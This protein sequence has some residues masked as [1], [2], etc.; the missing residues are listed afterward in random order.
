MDAAGEE[1]EGGR[2]GEGNRD[3]PSPTAD[4]THARALQQP[5][6][7]GHMN[8]YSRFLL[9]LDRNQHTTRL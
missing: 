5:G 4:G 1:A 9:G 7:R 2:R 3:T 6:W 8:T